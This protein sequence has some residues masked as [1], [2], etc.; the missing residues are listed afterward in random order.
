M[1]DVLFQGTVDRSLVHRAAV[2]EVFVTD[3]RQTS[4][5]H[6]LAGAQLPLAHSYYNDHVHHPSQFDA[7]LIAEA[8]RQAAMYGAHR[9]LDIPVQASYAVHTLAIQLNHGDGLSTGLVPGELRMLT[10]Y[11][12]VRRRAGEVRRFQV[13]QEFR[14]SGHRIGTAV[15]EVSVMSPAEYDGLRY[16]QRRSVA[17]TTAFVRDVPAGRSVPPGIVGRRNP[18]NVV[19]A[20]VVPG[21]HRLTATLRPYFGNRSLFDHDYD[22]YPAMVLLEAAR[23]AAMLAYGGHPQLVGVTARFTRFAELDAPVRVTTTRPQVDS[24][25]GNAVVPVTF[26]Q[27]SAIVAESECTVRPLEGAA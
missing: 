19:L 15:M 9:F 21:E 10:I 2:A 25:G 20:D 4:D 12:N 11:P 3:M 22:H 6:Y 7:L 23:Q 24:V 18:E 5:S 13:N 1:S 16:L 14:M 8:S 26:T 17:P 27:N